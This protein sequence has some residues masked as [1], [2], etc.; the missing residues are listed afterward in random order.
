[1][2]AVHSAKF[3]VGKATRK[4]MTNAVKNWQR[5]QFE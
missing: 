5:I 3:A 4:A 2:T 1:M